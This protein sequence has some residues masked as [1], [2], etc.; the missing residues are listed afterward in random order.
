MLQEHTAT[1]QHVPAAPEPVLPLD[2]VELELAL[3][4][5]V[6]G[7]GRFAE[8]LREATKRVDGEFLF[9]LPAS[10][11]AE[12][13]THIAALRIPGPTAA[14]AQVVLALLDAA[15]TSI[16]VEYPD[17]RTEDLKR[18]AEAFIGVLERI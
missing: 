15:G 7:Q 18:F 6:P 4:G 10:D 16:R 12:N 2:L 17:A 8:K 1:D 14:E 9:E 11:L 3:D 5:F 13:C